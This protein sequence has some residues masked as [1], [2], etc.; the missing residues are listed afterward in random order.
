[1]I[2][3]PSTSVTAKAAAVADSGLETT[4]ASRQTTY[5]AAAQHRL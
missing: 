5:P 3:W 1:M 2:T 4:P